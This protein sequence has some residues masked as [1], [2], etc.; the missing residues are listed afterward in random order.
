MRIV[1]VVQGLGMG[2][3]ERMVVQLSH[4]LAARGHE[5]AIVSLSPGGVVRA[6]A[7]GLSVVDATRHSG[8][9]GS[10]P[11]RLGA[12][13][14]RLRAD[15]VHTH[16][17][18][19]LL[20][21]VPAALIARVPRRVH[22]KHGAN[23]YGPRGLWAARALVWAIDAMV[24]V[25]AE[26]AAVAR[27]KERVAAA[28]LHVVPN[29]IPLGRFGRDMRARMRIRSE[30]GISA[31]ATV[32][33]SVG[34]LAGEKNY[35]LLVRALSPVLSAHVHL[36][37]VGEGP[38]RREIEQSIPHEKAAFVRLLGE[39]DDIPSVLAALDVFALS[40]H[41]E[42]LPLAVPEA[43]AS[44]LPVVATAVGGLPS[45][46]PQ[47]CGLLVPRG[48][49]AALREALTSLTADIPRARA[50]GEAARRHAH[51]RFSIERMTDAYEQLYERVSPAWRRAGGSAALSA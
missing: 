40:S 44:S 12:V 37:L 28:R 15:V 32:V 5:L 50:M 41:T 11:L 10:L 20:Y 27:S 42:G 13:L 16:N 6:Q 30:L 39:R 31:D 7:H 2:G 29:G 22:T 47:D 19:P 21:G 51:A 36:V 18:P 1:H 33:G 24:A 35:P 14:H 8:V 49:E 34:R 17:P 43:M 3:Q 46:V 9:D 23:T 48:D 25:S 38:A 4:E 26:T 45:S